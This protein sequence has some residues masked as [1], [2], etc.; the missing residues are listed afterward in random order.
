VKKLIVI[1]FL[2][3]GMIF[4]ACDR[5]RALDK[6]MADPQMKSYILTE[7]MKFEQ[8]KA[9]LADSLFADKALTDA[10]LGRLVQNEYTREDLLIR[11]MKADTSGQWIV[12]K[13][14]DEPRFREPMKAVS[15]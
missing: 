11:I 8:T 15:R 14:A 10:Y 9:Q 6:I 2:G 1:V 7:I 3:V 13:L 5:Q 4:A 12:T